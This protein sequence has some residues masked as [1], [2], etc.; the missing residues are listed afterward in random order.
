MRFNKE[1]YNKIED[2]RE[3]MK[4]ATVKFFADNQNPISI[5]NKLHQ[6]FFEYYGAK[7]SGQYG[8]KDC[9]FWM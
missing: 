2:P 9:L 7:V 3:L 5:D 8:E 6:N 4:R 1:L